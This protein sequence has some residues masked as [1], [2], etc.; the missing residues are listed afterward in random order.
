MSPVETSAF[1]AGVLL[2]S[3][4]S[5][6]LVLAG[7]RPAALWMLLGIFGGAALILAPANQ[8][9]I[10]GALLLTGA[11]TVGI[12]ALGFRR[13]G[14]RPRPQAAGS[15]PGGSGFRLAA[16]LLVGVATWG[17]TASAIP[18]EVPIPQA[19]L[20][21]AAFTFAMGLLQLGLS[22]EQGAVALGLLTALAGFELF[23]TALEPSLAL[24]AVLAAIML[25]I[26]VVTGILLESPAEPDPADRR[27]T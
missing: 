2:A 23:Y 21:V 12:L 1:V 7:S 27:R 13:S 15:I 20:S 6:G 22:Q 10:A 26:A 24:R 3:I 8:T 25:G 18:G 11:S 16:I 5:A 17:V 4:C 9:R 14:W 19:R